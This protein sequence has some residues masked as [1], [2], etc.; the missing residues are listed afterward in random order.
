GWRPLAD[1][2][3]GCGAAARTQIGPTRFAHNFWR[4]QVNPRSLRWCTADPGPTPSSNDP[5]PGSAAHHFASLRAALRPGHELALRRRLARLHPVADIVGV[6]A[7]V[8]VDLLH[9]DRQRERR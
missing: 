4:S 3:P 6:D 2:C 5:G 1:S 8:G 9:L 7:E